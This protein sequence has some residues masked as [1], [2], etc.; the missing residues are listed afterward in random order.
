MNTVK[1][2]EI[3]QIYSGIRNTSVKNQTKEYEYNIITLKNEN[4]FRIDENNLET[5]KTEKIL[6]DKYLLKKGDIIM[7]LTPPYSARIIEFNKE[8][9]TTTSNYAIIKVQEEYCPEIITFYLD[10]EYINKQI[11]HICDENNVKVI[12]ISNIKEF[13][14]RLIDEEKKDIYTELINTYKTKQKLIEKKIQLKHDLLEEII[15]GE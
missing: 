4:N 3:A 11:H 10:S 8:N 15:F 12:N 9:I 5:I 6:D 14:I 13:E 2:N 7:R 1:F